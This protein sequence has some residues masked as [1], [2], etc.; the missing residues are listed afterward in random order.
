MKNSMV[1]VSSWMATDPRRA[2]VVLTAIA[3]VVTLIGLSTGHGDVL[4][5][6]ATAGIG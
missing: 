1:M 6:R 5:G 2:K 4:A 3:V